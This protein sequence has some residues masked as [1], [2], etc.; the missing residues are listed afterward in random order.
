MDADGRQK[1]GIS[2][3]NLGEDERFLGL[4]RY[5]YHTLEYPL[6]EGNGD[7][8]IEVGKERC[9][10]ARLESDAEHANDS[11]V[12]FV[13]EKDILSARKGKRKK[14]WHTRVVLASDSREIVGTVRDVVVG[15]GCAVNVS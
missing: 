3:D 2:Y 8:E 5:R 9:T 13:I 14:M 12:M 1:A 6:I 11:G 4:P 10:F 15:P 7:K